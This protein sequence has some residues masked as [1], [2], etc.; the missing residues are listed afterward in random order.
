M[1][2]MY[3]LYIILTVVNL[4]FVFFK[5]I[6]RRT[7][8]FINGTRINVNNNNNNNNNNDDDNN[9][10]KC[11]EQLYDGKLGTTTSD[12]MYRKTIYLC[13][14]KVALTVFTEMCS[15][16]FFMEIKMYSQRNV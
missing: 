6:G 12:I 5:F 7:I 9:F 4:L 10:R 8:V 15:P 16:S 13:S 2:I 14:R 11:S 1:F 3:V